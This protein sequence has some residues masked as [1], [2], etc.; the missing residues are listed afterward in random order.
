[1][2]TGIPSKISYNGHSYRWRNAK[3]QKECYILGKRISVDNENNRFNVIIF[4]TKE[5]YIITFQLKSKN[6][7]KIYIHSDLSIKQIKKEAF[8]FM[9]ECEKTIDNPQQ[10][11]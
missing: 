9:K 8:Y 11:R 6:F 4:N 10:M 2:I 3:A 7:I 5:K 1:M